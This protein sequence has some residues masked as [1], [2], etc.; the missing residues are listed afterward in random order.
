MTDEQQTPPPGFIP[1]Q[2][3]SPNQKPGIEERDSDLIAD[4]EAVVGEANDADGV[5]DDDDD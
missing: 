1:Q 5:A 2:D 3:L 4:A